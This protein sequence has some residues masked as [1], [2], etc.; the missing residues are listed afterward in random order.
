MGFRDTAKKVNIIETLLEGKT[1]IAAR[2]IQTP[3]RLDSVY[4]HKGRD[5]KTGEET[6]EFICISGTTY[7]YAPSSLIKIIDEMF[8]EYG[9]DIDGVNESIKSE[10]VSVKFEKINLPDGKTYIKT[11][12][13]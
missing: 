7:F 12:I 3:V 4:P 10:N 11:I 8:T 2:D 13:I 6:K 9:G 1:K 5:L